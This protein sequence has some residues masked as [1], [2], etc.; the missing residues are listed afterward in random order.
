[1]AANNAQAIRHLYHVAEAAYED[2]RAFVACFTADGEFVEQ[3]RS[4]S[5]RAE[6][7]S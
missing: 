5:A 6:A 7:L 3:G 2:L 4:A 1:M